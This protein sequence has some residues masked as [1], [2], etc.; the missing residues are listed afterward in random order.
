MYL[1]LAFKKR[2]EETTLKVVD[3]VRSSNNV[4]PA[5]LFT[6]P[7]PTANI[8]LNRWADTGTWRAESMKQSW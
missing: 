2:A 1:L 8:R 4:R 5:L 3:S 6:A 7:S